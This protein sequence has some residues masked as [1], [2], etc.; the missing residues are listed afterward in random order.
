[1]CSQQ[2]E[3]GKGRAHLEADWMN[4]DTCQVDKSDFY[5]KFSQVAAAQVFVLGL[6]AAGLTC[7]TFG[8]RK[9]KKDGGQEKKVF[10]T[11]SQNSNSLLQLLFTFNVFLKDIH[12]YNLH[13]HSIVFTT[14]PLFYPTHTMLQIMTPHIL[15]AH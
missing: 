11:T 5:Y 3:T 12:L 7:H 14:P 1:M 8:K 13:I 6:G 15:I 4:F 2:T 10:A 9:N